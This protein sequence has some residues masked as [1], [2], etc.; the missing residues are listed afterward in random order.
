MPSLHPKCYL[1]VSI[2]LSKE[3]FA[4]HLF[5][6]GFAVWLATYN[7]W[8]EKASVPDVRLYIRLYS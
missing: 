6:E 3:G 7:S 1:S 4:V 5:N 8:A 2:Y